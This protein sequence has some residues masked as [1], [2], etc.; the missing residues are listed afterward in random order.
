MVIGEPL[1][2]ATLI[3]RY[4]R[5]LM[6][7]RFSDGRSLTVHCPNSGSME[8]CL[9]EGAPVLCSKAA[10]EKR[11]LAYTAECIRL[12]S[13]WVGINTH[14]TN[15]LAG[16]AL[17][18]RR[19]PELADYQEVRAEVP[20]GRSSRVD[21]LLEGPK[22]PPCYVEVKNTTWPTPDG[23]V[24]FPDAVTERGL[25]HLKELRGV[26]R[27]GGRAVMLYVVNREDGAF[28]RPALEKDPAY[29]RGLAQAL[30]A[31]VEIMARR[32]V[33]ALPELT[34]DG[35]LECFVYRGKTLV[36]AAA[37]C[38]GGKEGPA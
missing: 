15:L 1:V 7:V 8:G 9:A 30:R 5:F 6:D 33:F 17:R 31:G 21:F 16:E 34:L 35:A 11:K 18:T 20:Y 2:E 13:G 32:V 24:G 29:A 14:R 10:N 28:F 37:Y 25:K 27:N 12:P 23:G 26:V 19:I 3:R 4:K 36:T 38:L 22:L